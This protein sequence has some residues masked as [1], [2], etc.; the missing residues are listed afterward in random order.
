ML[1]L[2]VQCRSDPV[3]HHWYSYCCLVYYRLTLIQCS[4]SGHSSFFPQL[5]CFASD[6]CLVFL[7]MVVLSWPSIN[8]LMFDMHATVAYLYCISVKY[9]S[10]LI[11]FI[12]LLS[13][14]ALKYINNATSLA[15]YCG[16][17]IRL[18]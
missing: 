12:Y 3:F 15:N 14:F 1:W 8:C 2:L 17:C 7:G 6:S 18:K 16:P 9:F 13:S 5:H 4:A 10:Q 11:S